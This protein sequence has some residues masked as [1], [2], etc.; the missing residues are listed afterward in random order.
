MPAL[1]GE[2][3]SRLRDGSGNLIFVIYEFYDPTTY[4]MRDATQATSSGTKTGALIVDN[5]TGKTQSITATNP[6]T[7]TVKTFSIPSA[8]RVLTAAQLAAV[9]APNGPINTIQD[10]A[11]LSPSVT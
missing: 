4:A 7:G 1:S 5:M 8:G 10:L 3:I 6:E 2:V 9:P 11:G